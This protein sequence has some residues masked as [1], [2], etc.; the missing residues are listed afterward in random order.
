MS[1][2]LLYISGEDHHLRIPF[3]LALREQGF[4]VTAVG[5]GDP[6]PFVRVGLAYRAYRF[7]RFINPLADWAAINSLAGL[8]SDLRPDLAHSFDTKPNL[9]VPLAARRMPDVL[10]VRTVNGM[11]WLYSSRSPQAMALRP[12][13][14]AL[15]RLAAR[16]TAATVFQNLEDQ[17][18]FERHRTL[19]RGQ[20]LLIPGSGIDIERFD[21]ERAAGASPDRLREALG[22]GAAEVVITVTRMTRQKGIPTL[23]KAA[24]LVHEA[25]PGVR[26]LLVGPRESEGP[27]AVAQADIER[28]APYVMAIGPRSDVP[29]LLGLADVFAFPTE[30][31]EG[32]PRV[33][34]EAALARLPIVT[35]NMPGCSDVVRDGWNGLLVPPRAPRVLADRILDLLRDRQRAREMAVRAAEKVRQEFGLA[36]VVA[37][38]AALYTALLDGSGRG[39]F[40][41]MGGSRSGTPAVAGS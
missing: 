32:V 34:L 28:H 25:R 12:V 41:T 18:F 15:H 37:R 33:L 17:A 30:Y 21:R 26:F 31:R 27:F 23:L 5:T 10:V 22:L 8:L 20:S 24:A 7:D 1:P 29:A 36:A 2:H 13:F 9:L 6:D 16:W 19:G 38:Y 14:L 35:T 40:R 4:R 11:G 39:R 3:M